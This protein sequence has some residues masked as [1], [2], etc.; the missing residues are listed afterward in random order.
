MTPSGPFGSPFAV[1]ANPS[2]ASESR[3]ARRTLWVGLLQVIV[4]LR[5][6]S[7]LT[8]T[9]LTTV[10]PQTG[11]SYTPR[12]VNPRGETVDINS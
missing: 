12:I 6:Q 7:L 11:V 1:P 10:N 8:Q 9:I 4:T 3:Y 5:Y 2:T